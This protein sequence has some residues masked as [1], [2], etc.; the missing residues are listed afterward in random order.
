MSIQGL[1]LL[2]VEPLYIVAYLDCLQIVDVEVVHINDWFEIVV[3]VPSVCYTFIMF[4][5]SQLQ[6]PMQ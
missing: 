5:H 4:V 6:T 3:E 1:F 2:G